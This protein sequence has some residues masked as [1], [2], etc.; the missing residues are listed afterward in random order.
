[1]LPCFKTLVEFRAELERAGRVSNQD[2]RRV[3][4]RNMEPD[5]S[6]ALYGKQ[7]YTLHGLLVVFISDTSK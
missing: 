7:D 4:A 1:M 2:G 5:A 6:T 3:E